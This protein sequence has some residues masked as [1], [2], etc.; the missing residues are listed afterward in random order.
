MPLYPSY[1]SSYLWLHFMNYSLA[2]Q[3]T[4]KWPMT[5]MTLSYVNNC[6]R[7][8]VLFPS[9]FNFFITGP[10]EVFPVCSTK[11][12]RIDLINVIMKNLVIH[13]LKNMWHWCCSYFKFFEVESWSC[14]AFKGCSELLVRQELCLGLCLGIW[15]LQSLQL[16]QQNYNN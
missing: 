7:L 8:P 3:P 2:N 10:D 11:Y 14:K 13:I 12:E 4:F 1:P 15:A 6:F 9:I 5:K 16:E